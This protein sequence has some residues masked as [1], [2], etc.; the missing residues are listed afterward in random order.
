MPSQRAVA[1][2]VEPNEVV[3]GGR[4]IEV[5]APA[6]LDAETAR[7]VIALPTAP[8][9]V[10]LSRDRRTATL[11]VDGGVP[12][13]PHTL[14]VGEL[15]SARGERLSE[16]VEVPFFVSDSRAKVPATLR[17]ESIVRLKLDRL[18]TTRVSAATRPD[19]RYVE[20]MKAIHR[21]TGKPVALA[22]DQRGAAIDA[23]ALFAEIQRRR[24]ARFGKLH[25]VLKAAVE[26][27]GR[28][29]RLPVAVWL[30]LAPEERPDKR[31]KG[32]TAKPPGAEAELAAPY[33]RGGRAHAR[34]PARARRR[35][36]AARP[37]R[38]GR[39][40]RAPGRAHRAPGRGTRTSR[41][42]SCTTAAASSTSPTR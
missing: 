20:L 9:A 31:P 2:N 24:Q 18:G 29:E 1:V 34:G 39:L 40:R 38:A 15:V 8:A 36:A 33:R 30:R 22:F 16:P 32:A 13:G 5:R 27:A 10:S 42:S 11:D 7:A 12:P 19:G 23:D 6:A 14:R 3:L 35:R 28:E 25:P 17:V 41:R 21:R 37:P 4:P 26:A